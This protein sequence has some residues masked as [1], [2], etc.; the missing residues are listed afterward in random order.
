VRAWRLRGQP[1]R[2][3]VSLRAAVAGCTVSPR[4]F[5]PSRS[6]PIFAQ[7]GEYRLT[8]ATLSGSL[9]VEG[10]KMSGIVYGLLPAKVT[11]TRQK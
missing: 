10:D 2:T 11:M 4:N 9:T 8:G 3:K 6:A 7:E 1:Y 5:A